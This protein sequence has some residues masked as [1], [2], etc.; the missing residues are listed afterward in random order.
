MTK[1][2]IR[3][4]KRLVAC[5]PRRD[6]VRFFA[7]SFPTKRATSDIGR[8]RRFIG[9]S[10]LRRWRRADCVRTDS[11]DA[12]RRQGMISCLLTWWSNAGWNV[13]VPFHERTTGEARLQ[14]AATTDRRT[15]L[16]RG[17]RSAIRRPPRAE[18]AHGSPRRMSLQ[19]SDM[20]DFGRF[21]P[22]RN[23]RPTRVG[24]SSD[25]RASPARPSRRPT[26]GGNGKRRGAA[27]RSIT[28][29]GTVPDSHRIPC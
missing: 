2:A 3:A 18:S 13:P 1:P 22:A 17:A 26:T 10:P 20:L 15:R 8:R 27:Q 4:A 24:R 29:A 6:S 14:R 19:S 16:R 23:T 7:G 9:C 5:C 25:F 28:A 12:S 11:G 21:R